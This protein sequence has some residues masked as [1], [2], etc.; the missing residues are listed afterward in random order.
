[1]KNL[2]ENFMFFFR[3][4]LLSIACKEEYLNEGCDHP[5]IG[6]PCWCWSF[7]CWTLFNNHRI[8]RWWWNRWWW[9]Q[10]CWLSNRRWNFN[11]VTSFKSIATN[12]F[13][14][15]VWPTLTFSAWKLTRSCALSIDKR[16]TALTTIAR[17]KSACCTWMLTWSAVSATRKEKTW[18]TTWAFISIQSS[19]WVAAFWTSC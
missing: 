5:R 13:S 1:M 19:T 15:K 10:R 18:L 16:E 4:I 6:N 12:T 14:A 2:Y 7:L 9:R 3:Y 8:W 17:E 11:A